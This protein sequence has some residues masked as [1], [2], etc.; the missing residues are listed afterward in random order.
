MANSVTEFDDDRGAV[1]LRGI[2]V[3]LADP[4]ANIFVD[5]V[6]RYI[7]NLISAE[8]LR[9]KYGLLDEDA[10]QQLATNEPLQRAIAAAKTRRIHD[11]SAA[12]EKAAYYFTQAPDVLND[13]L[14][15]PAASPRHKIE[16][17]RELRAT[18]AVGS[19]NKPAND[20]ERFTI[21]IDLSAGGNK[22]NVIVRTFDTPAQDENEP[23]KTI[24]LEDNKPM[25]LIE[26]DE[27]D[28]DYEPPEYDRF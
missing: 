18:A 19:E 2:E 11:G 16:S 6:C 9:A 14:H 4:V 26:R 22:D 17:A 12:R 23:L 20:R 15:D 8:A 10:W 5:D 25:K 13:I 1:T 3:G 24:E 21:R 27:E 28:D 7:E